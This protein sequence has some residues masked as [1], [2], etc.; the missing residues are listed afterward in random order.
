[1][2]LEGQAMDTAATDKTFDVATSFLGG[3]SH[4]SVAVHNGMDAH[5]LIQRG[6]PAKAV[7]V[8]VANVSSM[9]EK[10]FMEKALGMSLRTFQRSKQDETRLLSPEQS[11]RTWKFVEIL[12]RATQLLGSKKDAEEWLE[13]PA[14]ALDGQCPIDLMTTPA[15]A[16]L[17]EEHLLRL[18][19]GVYV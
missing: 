6:I 13:K 15:G 7:Q 14:I 1:M 10:G 19:Y 9:S 12:A 17:V 5:K 8:L 4:L 16:K 2:T 18:E 3:Q 11:G